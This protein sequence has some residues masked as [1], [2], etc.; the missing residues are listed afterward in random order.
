MD[1][2][3]FLSSTPDEIVVSP[4]FSRSIW[5]IFNV[6]IILLLCRSGTDIKVTKIIS[7]F[8]LSS[9]LKETSDSKTICAYLGFIGFT[10]FIHHRGPTYN[11]QV[12]AAIT[13]TRTRLGFG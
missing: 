13:V 2:W 7:E 1:V 3:V 11:S 9:A 10:M 5:R 6:Q 12:N 4:P 8:K